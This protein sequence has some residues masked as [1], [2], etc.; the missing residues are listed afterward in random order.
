MVIVQLIGGLGNQMFQYAAARR[1]AYKNKIPLKLD[2]SG[3]DTMKGIT[4]RRYELSVFNIE[5]KFATED[6]I[7]SLRGSDPGRLGRFIYRISGGLISNAKKSYIRQKGMGFDPAILGLSGEVYMEGWWQSDKYFN[8]IENIIRKDFTIKIAPDPDNKKMADS[9]QEKEAV[10]IHIR[11]GDYVA[12]PEANRFHGVCPL[13][14]YSAALEVICKNVKNPYFFIF[15]D[16]PRWAKDNLK[17]QYPA[18]YIDHNGPEK[19]Y[20]D[21]RLMSLCKHHII[22]NS[23]FSWWGAW[24][25]ANPGK[26]IIAPKRW[27]SNPNIDTKD[28]IPNSWHRI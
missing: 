14:Y 15:S 13:E 20:E 7:A 24:L 3:F 11:R 4:K 6:E 28:L 25:S 5:E 23:V 10:S 21:L 1:V 17:L 12:N 26:I 9:I 22:A 2:I 27:F 19:G 16:E 18:V 8:D